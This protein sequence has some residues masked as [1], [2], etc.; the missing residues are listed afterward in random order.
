MTSLDS[1]PQP[2]LASLLRE[3]LLSGHLIDRAGMPY[4]ISAWGREEMAAIAIEEWMGASPNYTRRMQR[5]L[6]F[7]GD[8]VATIFK[9]MQFDI[10]AP[11]GFLDFRYVVHDSNSGGFQLDHCGALM[12]VEPMGEEY[13]VSMCHDIEDPTFDATASATNPRARMRP[14]HR[15]PRVPAGREP[16]CAWTV[17]IDPDAEPIAEAPIT[18][19][20][21]AGTLAGLPLPV[22]G[23]EASATEGD[24]DPEAGLW[25]DYSGD[26]VDRVPA[27]RFSSSALVAI[28]EELCLQ[29]H[30][31]SHAFMLAVGNRHG[32]QAALEMGEHQLVGAA[33][34]SSHRLAGAL[35]RLSVGSGGREDR[36]AGAPLDLAADV[37][38]LH[39]VLLPGSLVQRRIVRSGDSLRVDLLPCAGTEADSTWSTAPIWTT[40]LR[41]RGDRALEAMVVAVD[42]HLR[43]ERI[44]PAEGAVASWSVHAGAEPAEEQPEVLLA[45]F[46]TGTDFE[47]PEPTAVELPTH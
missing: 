21:A 11:H 23:R 41:D 8:D 31:L 17:E 13:V 5:L 26:L 38:E 33:G 42:P 32:A 46:S 37:L 47:L 20:V 44:D 40:L 3:Y 35:R 28:I 36:G 34:M 2:D 45:R 7:V 39:P 4:L 12:D 14:L 15:P 43:S 18:A 1:L 30:I 24:D 25:D 10:G 29:H 22:I 6:G 27:E 9:G 16:H 19:Q